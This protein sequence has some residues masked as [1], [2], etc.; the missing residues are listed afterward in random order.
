MGGGP[1]VP[2]DGFSFNIAAGLPAGVVPNAEE[3]VGQGL[4]VCFDIW[5]NGNETPPA[6]SIDVRYKGQVVAAA[7]L[8]IDDIV[9]GDD[10]RTVLLR[11]TPDG[12]L[13][14]V[15]GDLVVAAG[16][17]L[18]DYTPM[19]NAAAGFYSRTG[20]SNENVWIDNLQIEAKPTTP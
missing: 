18:P 12:K 3:G 9:T 1:A 7:H 4:S 16:V 17:Q 14:L 10:Y 19:T 8:L 13:D 6:P 20:G 11:V 2:A 15:Y 5:D